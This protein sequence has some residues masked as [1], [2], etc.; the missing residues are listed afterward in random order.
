[1]ERREAWPSI[2]LELRV[3]CRAEKDVCT[4]DIAW[5]M[6][7]PFARMKELAELRKEVAWSR[8]SSTER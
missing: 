4:V 7:A 1:M 6:V 3:V 2:W 8:K 5:A